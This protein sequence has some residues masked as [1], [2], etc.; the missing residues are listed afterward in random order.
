MK[1]N[2]TNSGKAN[3]PCHWL[4]RD[5]RSIQISGLH[6]PY[7]PPFLGGDGTSYIGIFRHK[8]YHTDHVSTES[9]SFRHVKSLQ[10]ALLS[11]QTSSRLVIW[12]LTLPLCEFLCDFLTYYFVNNL[13]FRH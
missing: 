4:S 11:S 2:F 10:L 6:D 1:M 12:S 13:A 8:I 9:Y 5:C 7:R 3:N